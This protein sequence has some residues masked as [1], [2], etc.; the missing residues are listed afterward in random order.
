[1][2]LRLWNC[3]EEVSHQFLDSFLTRT[4]KF[5]YLFSRKD[6]LF[7]FGTT[8]V[9]GQIY[10]SSKESKHMKQLVRCATSCCKFVVEIAYEDDG[11][12]PWKIEFLGLWLY[13]IFPFLAGQ[14]V[15][16]VFVPSKTLLTCDHGPEW[17]GSFTPLVIGLFAI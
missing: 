12:M 10:L 6:F 8:I 16:K 2:C 15:H 14:A 13:A 7:Y 5:L 3:V 4:G 11:M 9:C 17:V 1:M